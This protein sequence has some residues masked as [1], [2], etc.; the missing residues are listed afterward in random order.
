MSRNYFLFALSFFLTLPLLL[1]AGKAKVDYPEWCNSEY[2]RMNYPAEAYFLGFIQ[3]EKEDGET[4]DVSIQRVETEARVQAVSAIQ[5]YLESAV[6]ERSMEATANGITDTKELFESHT[7]LS[8]SMEISGL[9]VLSW[10][11]PQGKEV[12]AIAF[13]KKQTL[14]RQM[15]KKI[16]AGLTKIETLLNNADLLVK[17]GQKAQAKKEVQKAEKLFDEVY[18]A[19]KILLLA[20]PAADA[21]QAQIAETRQLHERYVRTLADLK[22]GLTLCV[23]CQ[24]L[25][26][27]ENYNS[28]CEELRGKLSVMEVSFTDNENEADYLIDIDAKTNRQRANVYGSTTSYVVM[29]DANVKLTKTA[30]SKLIYEDMLHQKGLHT[31]GYRDAGKDAYKTLLNTISQELKKYIE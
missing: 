7:K 1:F 3:S 8:V 15:D 11:N 10:H 4:V 14:V 25:L 12:A 16:I 30:G 18:E 17:N 5:T 31:M 19:Q 23:R 2:R 21:E 6:S 9:Q 29:A 26:E 22:N 27:D 20:D 24:A 28:F 13:I